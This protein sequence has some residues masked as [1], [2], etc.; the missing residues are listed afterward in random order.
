MYIYI[1]REREREIYSFLVIFSYR[2]IVIYSF[3]YCFL[4]RPFF[5]LQAYVIDNIIFDV[6]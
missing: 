4:C 6:K 3:S 2:F 5:V 1:Y